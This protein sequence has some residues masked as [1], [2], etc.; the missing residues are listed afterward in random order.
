VND[1]WINLLASVIAG[2]AV[3]AAQRALRY[4]R[5][6]VK[7]A[8]FGLDD[9]A[10][11]LLAVSR[12]AGS[13]HELSVHRWDVAALVE[14]TTVVK[15]CG[16]RVD[17]VAADATPAQ[18][19][20]VT[21]FS[22]GGPYGNQ[23]SATHLRTLLRGVTEEAHEVTGVPGRQWAFTV[24][25]ETYRRA[26]GREYVLLARAWGPSGSRPVFAI[27]GQTART[28]VAAARYLAAEYLRL[29]RRYGADQPFCLVLRIVEPEV[30]GTD[31][32]ELAADVTDQAFGSVAPAGVGG[33]SARLA[34]T[35][36]IRPGC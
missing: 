25:G 28:N 18:F 6:A 35:E 5:L 33:T 1:L 16:G 32:T 20:R 11:C 3:W 36:S 34:G 29:H 4:R 30:Y 24:A 10:R 23:R 19:G 8:F 27:A 13:P 26:A 7:R 15:D 17:L 22:V 9:G 2:T 12:H 14:L 21:E 31:F